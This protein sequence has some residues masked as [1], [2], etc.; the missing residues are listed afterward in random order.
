[1]AT[2]SWG[3]QRVGVSPGRDIE[4]A[5]QPFF[6]GC[7]PNLGRECTARIRRRFQKIRALRRGPPTYCKGDAMLNSKA[8]DLY[9]QYQAETDPVA[10][11]MLR[12]AYL[13]ALD[14]PDDDPIATR[15]V[16]PIEQRP[17]TPTA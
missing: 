4:P 5:G 17:G 2:G 11:E 16:R 8:R 13:R 14:E 10:E 12:Q 7:F 9:R 15:L 6:L 3:R 1:M